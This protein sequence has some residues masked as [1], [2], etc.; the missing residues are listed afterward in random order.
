MS[1]LRVGMVPG[2]TT[3]RLDLYVLINFRISHVVSKHFLWNTAIG[4]KT[5]LPIWAFCVCMPNGNRGIWTKQNPLTVWRWPPPFMDFS[6]FVICK[7]CLLKSMW[8][9]W[10]NLQFHLETQ[11]WVVPSLFFSHLGNDFRCLDPLHLTSQ[12]QT[13]PSLSSKKTCYCLRVQHG[14]YAIVYPQQWGSMHGVAKCY[15]N[16]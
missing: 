11:S 15:T 6:F 4:E 1:L 2:K 7:V 12:V 9:I 13:V 14:A 10:M 5:S 8:V 3:L 16:P